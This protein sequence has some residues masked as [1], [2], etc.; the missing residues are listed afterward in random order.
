MKGFAVL[1]PLVSYNETVPPPIRDWSQPSQSFQSIFGL[2]GKNLKPQTE[3]THPKRKT[4][5]L[6]QFGVLRDR[7]SHRNPQPR[8]CEAE[9]DWGA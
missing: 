2:E 1:K 9:W 6:P 3:H 8:T 7:N 5:Q 4:N